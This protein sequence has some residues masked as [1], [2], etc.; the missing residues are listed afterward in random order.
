MAVSGIESVVQKKR[1]ARPV[2][3]TARKASNPKKL[4]AAQKLDQ[5]RA[6]IK[7]L[8]NALVRSRRPKT[9]GL[10]K[11]ALQIA[12]AFRAQRL[13]AKEKVQARRARAARDAYKP[14]K[15]D[16]GKVV[17][18][19]IS[20]QRDPQAHGKRGYAVY[21]TKTGKKQ[22]LIAKGTKDAYRPKK[23][24]DVELPARKNLKRAVA[25]FQRSKLETVSSGREIIKGSGKVTIS[26]QWDF[27]NRVVEKLARSI[28]KALEAQKSKRSFLID[29]MVS[30][31]L[32]D[33]TTQVYQVSVPIDRPD[34]IAI[35]LGG[36][37]NFVRQKFYAFMARELAYDGYVSSGSYNH[38]R[39]LQ[40][41]AFLSKEYWL[42]QYDEKWAGIDKEVVHIEAIEWK[43]KQVK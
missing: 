17:L 41:N 6:E 43:I 21:V 37:L 15:K 42:N 36:I 32:P 1:G 23:I 27:N 39:K 14:R 11:T 4:T 40:V 9:K 7:K 28:K 16:R 12:Q 30:V 22:L 3:R 31:K 8:R 10:P 33:G 19:G 35:K 13:A 5:A 24:K 18:V 26:G 2:K 20:G 25:D 29:A 34:H 38:I